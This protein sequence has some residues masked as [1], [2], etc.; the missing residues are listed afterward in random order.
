MTHAT[1]GD[2]RIDLAA[3]YISV[4]PDTSKLSEGIKEAGTRARQEFE[5]AFYGGGGSNSLG[6]RIAQEFKSSFAREFNNANFLGSGTF[7]SKLNE[8]V[9]GKLAA[10]LRTQLPQALR[11]SQK[12]AD[13]LAEAEKRLAAATELVNDK[14]KTPNMGAYTQA[15]TARST[16]TKE[17]EEATARSAA[18]HEDLTNKTEQYTAASQKAHTASTILAGAMGGA[19]VGAIGLVVGG[20]EDLIELG[21]HLFEDAI[22]GAEELG[23]K[24]IEAGEGFEKINAQVVEY[25]GASGAA[26]AELQEHAASVFGTLDVEGKNVG[27]TMS[28][29]ASRLHMEP[30]AALDELTRKVTDLTGRFNDLKPATVATIFKDFNISAA[31]ANSALDTLTS[32]AQNA[33]VGVGQLSNLMAGPVSETLKEAGLS[34]GETAHV[35]AELAAQGLPAADVV[36][37]LGKAMAEY[38]KEG[39]S[40]KDGLAETR[41]ELQQL[42]DTAR[43]N[44]LADKLF[45]TKFVD[46]TRIID[47]LNE[48]LSQSPEAFDGAAGAADNLI[49]STET[50]DNKIQNLKNRAATAFRPLEEGAIDLVSNGLDKVQAWFDTNHYT[51]VQKVREWGDRFIENLPK[52]KQ[53][54]VDGLHILGPFA[55]ALKELALSALDIGAVFELITLH[56]GNADK[57]LQLED[58]IRNGMNFSKM[59]D[60]AADKINGIKIDTDSIKQGWNDISDNMAG[61][62]PPK[63]FS[64]WDDYQSP[65]F[66]YPNTHQSPNTPGA[67]PATPGGPSPAAPSTPP[68]QIPI[69]SPF[70][71]P[72]TPS[73]PN[74]LAPFDQPSGYTGSH[75]DLWRRVAQAE[76]SGNWSNADTGH[77]GHYGGLQFAPSTWALF[78]GTQFADRADHATAEQQMI[79]ADRTA[80]T[81]WNG[82]PPQGLGAWETITNGQVAVSAAT[83]GFIT[84]DPRLGM[85]GAPGDVPSYPMPGIGTR[86]RYSSPNDGPGFPSFLVPGSHTPR[87]AKDA[88]DT[89]PAWLS[90]GEFVVNR[91]ATE[92]YG[93]LISFLNAKGYGGGGKVSDSDSGVLQVIWDDTETGAKI[94]EAAGY[95]WVG[96]GTSQPGYYGADWG[97]HTGHVHTSF[98]RNPFTGEPYT[99]VRAGTDIRQGQPGFP[100]WVYQLGQQFGLQPSTYPGHQ[101]WEVPGYGNVNHGIDWWPKGKA[102]MAGAGYTHQ[103]HAMLTGFAQAV[104]A[105]GA[106]APGSSGGGGLNASPTGYGQGGSMLGYGGGSGGY[107]QGYGPGTPAWDSE[108]TRRSGAQRDADQ[109]VKDLNDQLNGPDGLNAQITKAQNDLQAE[110]NKLPQEQEPKKIEQLTKEVDRLTKQRDRIINTELPDAND[111]LREANDKLQEPMPG[112]ETGRGR[113]GERE[114]G[115]ARSFGEQIL[116]GLFDSLGLSNVEGLN[117]NLPDFKDPFEFSGVKTGLGLLN[118]GLGMFGGRDVG[119]S[120]LNGVAGPNIA[121]ALEGEPIGPF[122]FAPGTPTVPGDGNTPAIVGGS[123]APGKAPGPMTHSI[124]YVDNSITVNP[125]TDREIVRAVDDY[126]SSWSHAQAKAAPGH[127]A[128]QMV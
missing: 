41:K 109:R 26:L 22:H 18:A 99:Q 70:N 82:N 44:A 11:E 72:G 5:S 79:V 49:H 37:G 68:S 17:V 20:F 9:D 107:R 91:K 59:F 29:F 78:G 97:A 66:N 83:G 43:G 114:Y 85:P 105:L 38:S 57:L 54:V 33:G 53:F 120:V 35:T 87:G 25:S 1:S 104:G 19:M 126:R 46:A 2:Q 127:G 117:P 47:V 75:A 36:R 74:P 84:A 21:A 63:G 32:N 12:A 89:I 28:Q 45:G 113:R 67:S 27:Q 98:S 119:G 90:P 125:S 77:S 51:I 103:D 56:P 94:G 73:A 115:F 52:I 64:W 86:Q 111:R 92:K 116:S 118:W 8:E 31:Q 112:L 30:G 95:G 55:D 15:L 65:N 110:R 14:T 60:A 101:E 24:L 123:G 42:G 40:F 124:G 100:A 58:K 13:E 93:R 6:T 106:G 62:K 61:I 48:T 3:M 71:Q 10:R 16:A 108:Q 69:P 4:L 102:D 96:P 81:G 122:A 121:R 7:L 88:S 76:A 50:L 128:M 80:F 39:V 34:L 23:E